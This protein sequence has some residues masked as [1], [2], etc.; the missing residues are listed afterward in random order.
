M[1]AVL[2]STFDGDFHDGFCGALANDP[3]SQVVLACWH[4]LGKR[5]KVGEV[6][7]FAK[8]QVWRLSEKFLGEGFHRTRHPFLDR[9]APDECLTVPVFVREPIR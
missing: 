5:H 2:S 4:L 3:D 9:C 8:W 1:P 7:Y 6:D